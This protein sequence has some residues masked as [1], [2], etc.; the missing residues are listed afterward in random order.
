M[1][2]IT[3]TNMRKFSIKAMKAEISPPALQLTFFNDVVGNERGLF[4]SLPLK[5][6]EI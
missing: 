3:T 6:V 5:H 1:I 4:V 2:K